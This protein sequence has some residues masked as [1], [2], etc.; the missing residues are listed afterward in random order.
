VIERGD[1]VLA[2]VFGGSSR[3]GEVHISI[4][5]LACDEAV[6]VV[7]RLWPVHRVS[8]ADSAMDFRADFG[9]LDRTAVAFAEKRRLKHSLFTNS[10]DGA[11][12]YIGSPRSEGM[13]RLYK[14]SEQLRAMHP[15]VAADIPSFVVRAEFVAR[16]G[17]REAKEALSR[18][19]PADAW[20]LSQWGQEFAKLVLE[21]EPART[22]THFRRPS[23]WFRSLHWLGAQYGPLVQRRIDEEGRD[24]VLADVLA[25]LGL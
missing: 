23:D 20:G 16:P 22:S 12:R 7:R 18:L 5:G 10:E 2:T 15:E 4:T 9:L 13:C 17:K 19:E 11:T 24:A 3:A 6:P 14:K 1:D 21:L 25:A 8:R